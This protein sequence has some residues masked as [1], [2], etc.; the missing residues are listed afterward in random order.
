MRPRK[1]IEGDNSAQQSGG[2]LV[3]PR[4]NVPLGRIYSLVSGGKPAPQSHAISAS[5]TAFLY[6]MPSDITD[7]KTLANPRGVPRNGRHVEGL[8][9]YIRTFL[10]SHHMERARST[11]IRNLSPSYTKT[12]N[13]ALILGCLCKQKWQASLK[14]REPSMQ[15]ADAM[16]TL[17]R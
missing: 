15:D 16:Y 1:L 2:T 14:W 8:L 10:P 7:T 5:T 13:I 11:E 17:F 3:F 9:A 4:R 12:L 6:L